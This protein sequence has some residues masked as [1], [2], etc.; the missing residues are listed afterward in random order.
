MQKHGSSDHPD[1]ALNKVNFQV[2]LASLSDLVEA[3]LLLQDWLVTVIVQYNKAYQNVTSGG[4]SGI[5]NVD[6]NFSHCSQLQPLSRFVFSILL[7][8]CFKSVVK[9]FIQIIGHICSASS[10]NL[11]CLVS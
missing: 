1:P 5:Y 10:G 6:V 11:L 4:G 2:I 9:V 7:S 3:R 8:P